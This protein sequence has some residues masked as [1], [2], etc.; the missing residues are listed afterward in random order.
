MWLE[1]I[2]NNTLNVDIVVNTDV[3][4][5]LE[6]YIQDNKTDILC[7]MHRNLSYFQRMFKLN[8]SNRLLQNSKTALLIYNHNN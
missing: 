4:K 5:G 6:N 8:Y 2:G 3:E 1:D 7:I